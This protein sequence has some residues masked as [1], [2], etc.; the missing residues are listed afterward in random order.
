MSNPAFDKIL[1]ANRGEIALRI[2]R[3]IR[4][5]GKKSVAIYSEEDI[6]SLHVQY[7]DEAYYVGNSPATDSYLS[8]KNIIHAIKISGAQAIHPGYGFL[9]EN[10]QFANALK[11]QGVVLIGPS[12]HVIK[13]MGDKIAAKKI[14]IEAGMSTVPGY[15]GTIDN[16]KQAIEIAQDIGFPVIV[17][18][19]AGGGG[20]GMRVVYTAQEMQD[21]F[22]S[23]TI[24]AS[25]NFSDGRLFLEKFIISPRHIEIQLIADQHGNM[26]CLGERDC[27]TQRLHQKVIEECPAPSITS[28]IR[29]KMYQEVI[30]LSK[31]VGYYSAG[32]VEFMLDQDMNFYFLEMNT[33]L[34]VEHPITEM[35]TGVDIVKEMIN[36]AA[37][38]QLSLT[39]D[40]VQMKGWAIEARICAEDPIRGFLPS[41]GRITQYSEPTKNTNIRIDS[42]VGAGSSVSMFY[43]SM[44][45]KLCVY[46]ETRKDALSLMRV[47]LSTYVIQGITHNISFLEALI[48]HET[49]INAKMHT[50]FISDEYS[51]GFSGAELTSENAMTFLATAMFCRM[52]EIYRMTSIPDQM[53]K[54]INTVSTRFV[55]SIDDKLFPILIKPVTDGY[56]IRQGQNR[57]NIRGNWDIGS[58]LFYATVNNK[59]VHVKIEKY[60]TGYQLT[61]GGITVYAYVRSPRTSELEAIVKKNVSTLNE[62]SEVHAPIAGQIIGIHVKEGDDVK[63]GQTLLLLTAMKMEN[64]II[65]EKNGIIKKIHIAINDHVHADQILIELE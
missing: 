43:D 28:D 52:S 41:S 39:Q 24:E 37:G 61:H 36:I 32:T 40:E 51:D 13:Q 11:R 47:A 62:C 10:P 56:N 20:R 59:S 7:A 63:H 55:V 57:I 45:A 15:V 31:K 54:S 42:G 30:K 5:M 50:G 1:V 14:A 26:V 38:E 53:I 35:V 44:I 18:A 34:Q 46:G 27:S 48:S 16:V 12:A 3:T 22:V 19:A 60:A 64:A 29:D 2:M 9:S 49:F 6:N 33:R 58:S 65:A 8:I 25:N 23:A 4:E 21:A 17:K